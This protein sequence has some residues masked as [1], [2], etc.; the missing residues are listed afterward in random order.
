ML[1]LSLLEQTVTK[2]SGCFLSFRHFQPEFQ[3]KIFSICLLQPAAC[4]DTQIQQLHTIQHSAS[5][6][7]SRRHH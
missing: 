7:M 1:S 4:F 5:R 3:H 6:R 2:S